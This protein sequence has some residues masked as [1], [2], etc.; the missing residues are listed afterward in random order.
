[1]KLI[2]SYLTKNPCYQQGAHL[3][4]ICIQVHSIGTPQPA[5]AKIMDN[6]NKSSA[7]AMVHAVIEPG[8]N[9]YEIMQYDK[10]PWADKG[11]GNK[12]AI[13]F[14]MTE[15]STIR[16]T[17]GATWIET[18]DGSNTKAHVLDTY[19]TAV[20][21]TAYL[22]QKFGLNPLAK[23]A[24]GV[25]VVFSHR[26]GA[27]L[28]VSSNHGDPAHLWD[29]YGLT[30]DKFRQ[31]V[32]IK[33]DGGEISVDESPSPSPSPNP[34]PAPSVGGY[35]VGNTY[36]LQANMSVRTGPGTNYRRKSHSE[37]TAD[38]QAHDRDKNGCLEAGTVVTCQEVVLNGNQIW[39]RI[40]SGWVC[41][42]DG[43]KIYISSGVIS[44]PT[45]SPKPNPSIGGYVVGNTYTLQA[46]MSVRTG[47]GTSYRRK[48]HSELTADGQAHDRDKNGCLDA[49]TVITCQEIRQVGSQIWIKA[50]S[51]W[52]CARDG[53]T[54]YIS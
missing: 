26:E 14:E 7:S 3:N 1:M 54:V 39:I 2:K 52:L 10:R 27:L 47:P 28:G 36:T 53:D 23:T 30:M 25:P 37:L 21:Y 32:K 4:P 29:K 18:G 41:A 15:P 12:H 16:Y 42:V 43:S 45:P 50:P 20:E 5:A 19:Q 9:V 46:N 13:A 34:S 38:G 8:G 44:V 6:W 24:D 35:V 22:C 51:G 11:Y 49:G 48:S 31:D 33:M 17:G 40:P